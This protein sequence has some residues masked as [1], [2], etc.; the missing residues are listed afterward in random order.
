M[1]DV[2]NYQRLFTL[3]GGKM[4]YSPYGYRG[5]STNN[6]APTQIM[7]PP[8]DQP[9]QG[10]V[11]PGEGGYDGFVYVSKHRRTSPTLGRLLG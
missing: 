4:A 10:K 7:S 5:L 1:F 9:P 6:I 11:V 8:P 2:Y 3:G